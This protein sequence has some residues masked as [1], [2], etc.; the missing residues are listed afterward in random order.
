MT[1]AVLHH[2][3]FVCVACHC[4]AM[5]NGY[6]CLRLFDHWANGKLH[7]WFRRYFPAQGRP[8]AKSMCRRP[9]ILMDVGE[10]KSTATL[11]RAG[12]GSPPGDEATPCAAT[13]S[14][15]LMP[16]CKSR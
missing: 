2:G 15:L 11:H 7:L 13:V 8:G 1:Y 12:E 10:N 6:H 3:N 16:D 5:G 14:G 9:S 4:Q